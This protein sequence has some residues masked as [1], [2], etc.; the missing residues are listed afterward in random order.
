[1]TA[2][3]SGRSGSLSARIACRR[4]LHAAIEA[5]E[6]RR[7]LASIVVNTDADVSA[8]GDGLVT[9]REAIIAANN[10]TTTD[11]GQT[12]GGADTITFNLS[13]GAHTINLVA[14]LPNLSSNLS[15]LNLGPSALT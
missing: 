3:I 9:L 2:N 15:I 1:M 10:D 6:T 5:L 4:R 11:T 14:G 7:L 8:A 12:G 13:P